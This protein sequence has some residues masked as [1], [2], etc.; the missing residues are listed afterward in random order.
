M[1]PI[2]AAIVG[3]LA[4]AATATV[5]GAAKTVVAAL[6]K[7][8]K[9]KL[10]LGA[11]I[12]GFSASGLAMVTL[13]RI[14]TGWNQTALLGF[15]T[16]LLIV[17]TVELGILGVLKKIIDPDET[18]GLLDHLYKNLS[19]RF[20]ALDNRLGVST[21]QQAELGQTRELPDAAQQ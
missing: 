13:S 3:A 4:N 8:Y 2:L 1:D 21:N 11:A 17:G 19:Q 6:W 14:V 9:S 16:S 7:A 20:D 10:A 5:E 15:G 18:S 12:F